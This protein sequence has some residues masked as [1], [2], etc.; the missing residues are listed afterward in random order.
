MQEQCNLKQTKSLG[1]ILGFYIFKEETMFKRIS[2]NDGLS[3]FWVERRSEGYVAYNT[4][5]DALRGIASMNLMLSLGQ[6]GLRA[7]YYSD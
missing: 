1:E 6:S 3:S 7:A 2:F 4:F 5:R